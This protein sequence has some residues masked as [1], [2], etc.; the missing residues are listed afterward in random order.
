MAMTV[1]ASGTTQPEVKPTAQSLGRL[2][3]DRVESS[4]NGEA[5]RY[6]SGPGWAQ[7]TWRETGERVTNLAAGLLALG[8]RT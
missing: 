1:S 4:P 7:L 2:L 5:F 3:L 8:L 6:P